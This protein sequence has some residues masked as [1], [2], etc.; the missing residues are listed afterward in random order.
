MNVG[1][2]GKAVRSLENA[3]HSL[4][5]RLRGVFTT[6]LYINPRLPYLYLYLSC[7]VNLPFCFLNYFLPRYQKQL[8]FSAI[9]QYYY[10]YY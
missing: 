5:V 7:V 8:F 2:A 3:C 10:Y 4:P 1:C 6:R 9:I